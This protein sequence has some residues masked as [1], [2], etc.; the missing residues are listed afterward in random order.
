[1]CLHVVNDVWGVR[2]YSHNCNRLSN[3]ALEANERLINEGKATLFRN[4]APRDIIR[5]V[6][7]TW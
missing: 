2:Q 6:L 5:H 1:M 7:Q 3:V 4:F